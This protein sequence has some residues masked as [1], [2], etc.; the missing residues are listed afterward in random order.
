M[1]ATGLARFVRPGVVYRH[2]E[3]MPVSIET[4]LIWNSCEM[5]IVDRFV[6]H[7]KSA[8]NFRRLSSIRSYSSVGDAEV[9]E[10]SQAVDERTPLPGIRKRVEPVASP[11]PVQGAVGV[12]SEGASRCL[13]VDLQLFSHAI[14][15]S[16]GCDLLAPGCL[17]SSNKMRVA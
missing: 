3:D 6:N 10:A 2:V 8:P 13:H 11:V 4:S 14:Y 5:P 1:G 7:I 15:L 12:A 17:K 16:H 9:H